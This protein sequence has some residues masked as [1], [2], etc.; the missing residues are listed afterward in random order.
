M[1]LLPF[2]VRVCQLENFENRITFGEVMGKSLVYCFLLTY[3]VYCLVIEV[4]KVKVKVAHTRLPSV[5]FWS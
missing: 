5:W 3:G 1:I 4:K 2:Y